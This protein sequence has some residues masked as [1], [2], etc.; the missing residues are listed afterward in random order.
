MSRDLQKSSALHLAAQL[1]RCDALMPL[2]R[3]C[4]RQ[5][6][7]STAE[8][9]RELEPVQEFMKRS[10]VEVRRLRDAL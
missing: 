1:A 9:S 8:L 7:I 3:R 5:K 10:A 6:S 4:E 2:L